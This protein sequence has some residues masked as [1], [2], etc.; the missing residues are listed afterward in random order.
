MWLYKATVELK[1]SFTQVVFVKQDNGKDREDG[2]LRVD[3][4]DYFLLCG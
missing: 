1:R 2:L 3:F 4:K